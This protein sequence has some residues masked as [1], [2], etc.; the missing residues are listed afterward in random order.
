LQE[1]LHVIGLDLRDVA[2]V[3]AFC[4]FVGTQFNKVDMIVNNACQTVGLQ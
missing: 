2:G 3:E 4:S 1:R